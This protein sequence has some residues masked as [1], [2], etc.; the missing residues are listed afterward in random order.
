MV[1]RV[2]PF[3]CNTD[4]KIGSAVLGELSLKTNLLIYKN[5]TMQG[6]QTK[7][8]GRKCFPSKTSYASCF[9]SLTVP[10]AGGYEP[11]SIYG[12]IISHPA[13][14]C[15]HEPTSLILWPEQQDQLCR[16]RKPYSWHL[17]SGE[18]L[19]GSVCQQFS[20]LVWGFACLI[21]TPSLTCIAIW[22]KNL[23]ILAFQ[24]AKT[25]C[26]PTLKL[27]NVLIDRCADILNLYLIRE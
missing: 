20:I 2:F 3:F 24:C 23:F 15:P 27:M 4:E 8:W 26:S 18:D 1:G 12:W 11:N 7:D 13:E 14:I 17:L 6:K 22:H 21:S 25:N 16:H 5:V 10:E 9:I 19:F